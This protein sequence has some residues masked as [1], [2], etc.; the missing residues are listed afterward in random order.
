M[1]CLS[2][3][4]N[5]FFISIYL[6]RKSLLK[7]KNVFFKGIL[8]KDTNTDKAQGKQGKT[9]RYKNKKWGARETKHPKTSQR[10]HFLV[11]S[12]TNDKG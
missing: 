5:T 11:F 3:T 1:S 8:A 7:I 10:L 2:K 9:R 6:T 4:K 12:V